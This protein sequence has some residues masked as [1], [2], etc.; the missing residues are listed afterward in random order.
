[1]LLRILAQ[2]TVPLPVL[3]I[4]S[5]SEFF[6][7]KKIPGSLSVSASKHLSILNKKKFSRLSDKSSKK[8]AP[9]PDLWILIFYPSRIQGSKRHRIRIRNTVCYE[10]YWD[11][12]LF[13]KI[14]WSMLILLNEICIKSSY[15]P[16]WVGRQRAESRDPVFL[17]PC[18]SRSRVPNQCGSTRKR[19]LVRL[20]SH[21]KLNF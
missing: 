6:L 16:F 2:V 12:F 10:T 14:N 17:S 11:Y 3:Q 15:G 19:I 21:K 9:D 1:M 20:W 4:R 13:V 8:F 18:G 7:V 5:G